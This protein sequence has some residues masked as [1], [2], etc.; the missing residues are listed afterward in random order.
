MT[1]KFFSMDKHTEDFIQMSKLLG[2][3]EDPYQTKESKVL[4]IKFWRDEGLISEDEA[5][6]LACEFC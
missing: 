1:I 6:D 2:Y 4:A 5:I 3:L